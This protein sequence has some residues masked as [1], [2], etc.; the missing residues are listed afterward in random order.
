MINY[1]R[2]IENSYIENFSKSEDKGNHIVF[3]D[4]KLPDMHAFNCLLIKDNMNQDSMEGFVLNN[5]NQAIINGKDFLTIIFHPQT[6]IKDSLKECLIDMGFEIENNLYMKID[7]SKA[8]SLRANEECVVKIAHTDDEYEAGRALDIET[9]IK[10]GIPME[11]AQRKTLRKKE[12]FQSPSK[13]LYSYLCY[14]ENHVIGK[15]ELY[16]KDQYAKIEDFEVLEKYQRRGFGTA[17]L[18][19]V[20]LDAVE[21]GTKNIYLITGKEDTPREMYSK[22]GFE[23]IGEEFKVFWSK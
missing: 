14:Y 22:L 2:D 17:I 12:V 1:F 11:F 19:R 6:V 3:W 13:K 16:I 20:I 4:D 8:N 15:C 18:K 21:L 5:L 7:G 9:C 23:I 10:S